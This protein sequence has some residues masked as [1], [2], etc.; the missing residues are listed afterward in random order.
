MRPQD[1]H[2]GDTVYW[3]SYTGTVQ[4]VHG[5]FANIRTDTGVKT[6]PVSKLRKEA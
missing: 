4:S 6:V 2:N 3:S 1:L 5:M